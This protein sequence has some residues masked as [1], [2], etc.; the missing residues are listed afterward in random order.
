MKRWQY[1]GLVLGAFLMRLLPS[2]FTNDTPYGEAYPHIGIFE[3][4]GPGKVRMQ[5]HIHD[6][7]DIICTQTDDSCGGAAYKAP[8]L[9]ATFTAIPD[10]GY[11]CG[12]DR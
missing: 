3:I 6:D 7:L 8:G 1:L 2:C 5:F 12:L 4:I 11:I 9:F 10:E